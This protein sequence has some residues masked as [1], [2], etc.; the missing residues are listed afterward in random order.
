MRLYLIDYEALLSGKQTVLKLIDGFFDVINHKRWNN[1][2]FLSLPERT[3]IISQNA[4]Q[5]KIEGQ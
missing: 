3:K 2:N 1:Q 5:D 4:I